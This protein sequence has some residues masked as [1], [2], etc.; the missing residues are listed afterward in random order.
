MNPTMHLRFVEK[1]IMVPHERYLNV[2][3]TKTVSILQQKWE[4]TD[5]KTGEIKVLWRD[6]PK[7]KL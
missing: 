4:E 3:Y 6:V 7:E 5:S 2:S 1:D